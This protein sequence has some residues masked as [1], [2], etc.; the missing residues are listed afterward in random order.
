ME[1]RLGAGSR[2]FLACLIACLACGAGLSCLLPYACAEEDPIATDPIARG[3]YVF[4]L[5][6]GCGCHT[7]AD[8]QVNA[9]GRPLS[10]PYGTFYGTNI[11]P[12]ST[13]GIGSWT[14]RQIIDAIRSGVRPD[15]SVMSPV[16]PYPAL[17]GMSDEDV[18][19][20]VAYLRS[21][22]AVAQ[23]NQP[24]RLSL[25]FAGMAMKV[26]DWHEGHIS[27]SMS[28]TARS[29]IRR[30]HSLERWT[31]L[32]IWLVTQ[33]A[34]MGRSRRILRLIPRPV[35]ASGVKVK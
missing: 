3:Q 13:H 20:L 8:G 17:S 29:V 22:P 32:D 21:L 9:G 7:A 24:H 16:M 19:A 31:G 5:A 18:A 14:D 6:G 11:T 35:L 33:T 23:E 10:T 30:V 25:P 26:W 27:V 2:R 15:G 4:A 28:P 34:L 1:G 12:D